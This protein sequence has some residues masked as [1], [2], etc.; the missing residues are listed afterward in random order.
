MTLGSLSDICFVLGAR[1][2]I[3]FDNVITGDVIVDHAN[4]K[5]E[6]VKQSAKSEALIEK[7]KNVIDCRERPEW[8]TL[9]A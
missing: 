8:K 2:R 6:G 7:S 5:W 3:S 9:A 1:P 4:I